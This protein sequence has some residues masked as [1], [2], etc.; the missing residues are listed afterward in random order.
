MSSRPVI[1]E[2]KKVSVAVKSLKANDDHLFSHILDSWSLP[3]IGY[4]YDS[5]CIYVNGTGASEYEFYI[6]LNR[7]G[8]LGGS[9]HQKK[10]DVAK[11][12]E[13]TVSLHHHQVTLQKGAKIQ[14]F[15]TWKNR[16]ANRRNIKMLPTFCWSILQSHYRSFTTFVLSKSHAFLHAFHVRIPIFGHK[17]ANLGFVEL[18]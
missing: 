18:L 5:D 17:A 9:D 6:Q 15:E 16:H 8:T 7:C 11:N 14:I 12:S 2:K 4:S 3:L 13:P 1:S 10:R